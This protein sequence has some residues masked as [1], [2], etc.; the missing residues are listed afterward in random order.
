LFSVWITGSALVS[1]LE[2]ALGTLGFAG[3]G[4]F[5]GLIGAKRRSGTREQEK[6]RNGRE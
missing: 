2:H 3:D 1:F 6:A 5:L 4:S